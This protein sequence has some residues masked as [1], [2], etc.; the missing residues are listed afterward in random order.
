MYMDNTARIQKLPSILLIVLPFIGWVAVDVFQWEIIH[1]VTPFLMLPLMG[2]SFAAA[3]VILIICLVQTIRYC[4]IYGFTGPSLLRLVIITVL[5][6]FLVLS[7]FLPVADSYEKAR[8]SAFS[9]TFDH[10]AQEI[11][12][13]YAD[14]GTT[15]LPPQYAFLSR[16]GG[17]VMVVGEDKGRAVLFYS[18]RGIMDNYSVY[19]YAPD[20]NAFCALMDCEDWFEV[21]PLRE[22]WYFCA[23][24]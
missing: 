21:V 8:F 13:R 16:G 1:V 12:T 17:E 11:K 5:I 20:N 9:D 6:V 4:G 23:S 19:A 22:H 2:V 15:T 24:S 10:A 18:Y 14:E 7:L 3:C